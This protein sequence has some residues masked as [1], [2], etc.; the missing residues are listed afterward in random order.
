MLSHRDTQPERTLTLA[1]SLPCPFGPPC[2]VIGFFILNS[3][4][5]EY[6]F[7]ALKNFKFGWYMTAFELLSFTGF[8]ML[9]RFARGVS[10]TRLDALPIL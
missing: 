9:E 5:E 10:R 1:T 2:A 6:L 3:F 8:A 7:R 4:L